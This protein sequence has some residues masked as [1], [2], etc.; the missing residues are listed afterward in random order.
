MFPLNVDFIKFSL[1]I[2]FNYRRQ[3]ILCAD[4]TVDS[5]YEQDMPVPAFEEVEHRQGSTV[6]ALAE[7]IPGPSGHS[8]QSIIDKCNLVVARVKEGIYR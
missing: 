8:E 7:E 6:P 1:L 2:S 3:Q 4:D 5:D